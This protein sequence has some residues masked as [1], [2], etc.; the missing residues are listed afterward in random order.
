VSGYKIGVILPYSG[1]DAADGQVYTEGLKLAVNL[2]N[3][4]NLLGAPLSVSYQ[5]NAGE[6]PQSVTALQ[7][8]ARADNIPYVIT[9]FTGPTLGIQPAAA[10][11][12]V[13]LVN[14]GATSPVL[15]NLPYLYNV[16][17]FLDGE[18]GSL[19]NYLKT[20]MSSVKR[21]SV[22]Y[23]NDSLG[24]SVFSSINKAW[25]GDG[26]SVVSEFPVTVGSS[27]FGALVSEVEASKPDL[28]FMVYTGSSE[29]ALI[30]QLKE[31]GV[32]ATIAGPQSI[33]E[34]ATTDPKAE[35]VIYSAESL[36]LTGSDQ[37]TKEFVAAFSKAYPKQSV[38][39]LALNYYNS[40]MLYVTAVN[41]LKAENLAYN[42][43][44][45]NKVMNSMTSFVGVGG[46]L[47]LSADHTITV[48]LA[49]YKIENGKPVVVSNVK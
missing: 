17:P 16:T 5:D 31:G 44:N 29:S 11:E 13:V 12:Q 49:I 42:G 20:N 26:R 24:K 47:T 41:K 46:T 22:I 4:K 30:D 35:G 38:N 14:G 28:V 48:P 40:V 37:D 15:K 10:R 34:S 45:L 2:V 25:T 33:L 1:V 36:P 18:S 21:M 23:E 39:Q 9:G 8:L 27:S 7:Q 32:T 43:A 19:L 6:V 3:Q